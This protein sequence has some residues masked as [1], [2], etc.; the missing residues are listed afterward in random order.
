MSEPPVE[1]RPD[2]DGRVDDVVIRTPTLVRME[3]MDGN[4]WW[5]R[6]EVDGEQSVIFHIESQ[7]FIDVN[8][9]RE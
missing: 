4:R 7:T 5:L 8:A 3:R 2:D 6:I 1:I 9:E